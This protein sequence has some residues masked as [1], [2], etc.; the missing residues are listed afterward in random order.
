VATELQL[1]LLFTGAAPAAEDI[2]SQLECDVL[3][4]H[5]DEVD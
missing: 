2:E 3:E 1:I 5:E 4:Y